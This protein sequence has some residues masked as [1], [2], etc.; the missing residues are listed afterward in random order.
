M[1]V[2]KNRHLSVFS[3]DLEY[4]VRE[5]GRSLGRVFGP[6]GVSTHFQMVSSKLSRHA[7]EGCTIAIIF[8]LHNCH[9]S[10]IY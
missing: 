9:C 3:V 2:D 5:D 10:Y 6:F 7:V 4:V 1:L 8:F